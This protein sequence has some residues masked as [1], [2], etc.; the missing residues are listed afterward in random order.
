MKSVPA[1]SSFSVACRRQILPL[2]A[3]VLVVSAVLI[4]H[5][6]SSA[7]TQFR[8]A[9]GPGSVA[10]NLKAVH[11]QMRHYG[12]NSTR[13]AA[14]TP[15]CRRLASQARVL[16]QA[17]RRG[18]PVRA[19][20]QPQ[21]RSFFQRL[22]GGPDRPSTRE[23]SPWHDTSRI[24]NRGWQTP[25][26]GG[27]YRTLCVRTCDGYYFPISF[28]TTRSRFSADAAR[29]EASCQSPAK[30]FVYANPGGSPENMYDLQGK[31]Y[32]TMENAFLYRTEYKPDCRCKPHPW[33]QEAKAIYE[34]RALAAADV[35]K[36]RDKADEAPKQTVQA[37]TAPAPVVKRRKPKRRRTAVR[38][39]PVQQER[40]GLFGGL[41]R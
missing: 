18:G 39:A 37:T 2:L 22:F 3:L 20:V 24:D 8:N 36:D 29:C 5:G 38:R 30:L 21:R 9:R 34:E 25:R 15:G 33:S 12:C 13:R 28:S 32:S 10:A 6:T 35:E 26:G 1:R 27:R 14:S 41:F 23:Q 4:A 11:A 17:V 31:P 7:Q 40:R 16:S 19:S